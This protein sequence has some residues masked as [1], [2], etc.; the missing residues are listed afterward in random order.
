MF[1][2][3][4]AMLLYAVVRPVGRAWV[5]Q[6]LIAAAAFALLP[7]LNVLTTD[8]HL[9]NSLL[10]HDWVFAGFD[11]AMLV[12]GL[13]FAWAARIIAIRLRTGKADTSAITKYTYKDIF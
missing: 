10:T 3:W 8:R 2:I 4:A 11:L 13:V 7:F 12:L 5:E 1:I 6:F 9:I